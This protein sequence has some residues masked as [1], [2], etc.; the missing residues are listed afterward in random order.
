MQSNEM[1]IAAK[2]RELAII[3]Q[4]ETDLEMKKEAELQAEIQGL[5]KQDE[6]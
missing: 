4:G 3:Q 6:L 5:L 1:N 2:T